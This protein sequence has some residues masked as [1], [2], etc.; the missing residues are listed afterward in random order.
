MCINGLLTVTL[1][2]HRKAL[3]HPLSIFPADG[4][5]F[6][7]IL[8]MVTATEQNIPQQSFTVFIPNVAM[9]L[10]FTLSVFS[11]EQIHFPCL[12]I[13]VYVSI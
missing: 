2:N 7:R 13:D 5:T 3:Y 10:G 8:F 1:Q 11:E 12:L 6:P 4:T 9:C